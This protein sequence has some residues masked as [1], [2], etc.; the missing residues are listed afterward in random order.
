[1]MYPNICLIIAVN[2]YFYI[3]SF[4]SVEIKHYFCLE[5]HFV[6]FNLAPDCKGQS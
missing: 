3:Y 2:L 4:M 5:I 1:M 6:N